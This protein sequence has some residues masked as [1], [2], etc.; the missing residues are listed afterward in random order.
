ME[1]RM[2]AKSIFWCWN[3]PL[4]GGEHCYD[5]TAPLSN[6]KIKNDDM[7]VCGHDLI[8]TLVCTIYPGLCFIL[9]VD[10]PG[11]AT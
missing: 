5:N 8:E 4:R 9:V 1:F 2:T 6:G 3:I 10:E 11:T 7:W